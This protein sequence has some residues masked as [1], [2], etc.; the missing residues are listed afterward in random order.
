MRI[1]LDPNRPAKVKGAVSINSVSGAC[2]EK[3]G[4]CQTNWAL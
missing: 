2:Q 4:A 3:E 1:S